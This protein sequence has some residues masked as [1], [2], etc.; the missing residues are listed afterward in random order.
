MDIEVFGIT[1]SALM[2]NDIMFY[3]HVAGFKAIYSTELP[4]TDPLSRIGSA[5]VKFLISLNSPSAGSPVAA[6]SYASKLFHF[7]VA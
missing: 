7:K 6:S 4:T 1:I 3:V 5:V 2:Y